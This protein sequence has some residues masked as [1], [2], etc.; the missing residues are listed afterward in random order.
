MTVNKNTLIQ[1]EA[2]KTLYQ[3]IFPHLKNYLRKELHDC[4]TVLDIGCGKD[5][6]IQHCN[7]PFSVGIELF[8]PYLQESQKK[9]IHNQYIKADIRKIEFKENS[10]DVVLALDVIEHL[11]KDEGY[12]LILKAQR[13]AKKKVIV[14]TPNGF[15]WQED[16]EQN[17]LQVHRSGWKLHELEKQ[18]FRVYGMRGWKVLYGY[19]WQLKCTQLRFKPMFLWEIIS[20]ITQKITYF[21][22]HYAFALLCIWQ[23]QKGREVG[24]E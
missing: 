9:R 3:K 20:G 10:F 4:N 6:L 13:W 12:E 5:S 19:N 15:L 24:G 22:P 2:I 14:F 18:G 16:Y 17:P 11:S 8:E 21:F 23:K 1:N 7:V